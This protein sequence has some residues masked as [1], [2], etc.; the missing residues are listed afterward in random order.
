MENLL[1][2]RK[3]AGSFYGEDKVKAYLII[4]HLGNDDDDFA[5]AI[6]AFPEVRKTGTG[7][8]RS[9]IVI[10]NTLVD[11]DRA[12]QAY[13]FLCSDSL[14]GVDSGEIDEALAIIA[15]SHLSGGD[16]ESACQVAKKLVTDREKANVWRAI[17]IFALKKEKEEKEEK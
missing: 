8:Y 6:N 2:A 1:W 17:A 3:I 5:S 14:L 12:K 16:V 15:V 7:I 10:A 11:C 4:G 9:L 13:D